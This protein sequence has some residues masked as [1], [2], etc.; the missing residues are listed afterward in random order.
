MLVLIVTLSVINKMNYVT[1][2]NCWG[3]NMILLNFRPPDG[4]VSW[5]ASHKV[6]NIFIITNKNTVADVYIF[7]Y[8]VNISN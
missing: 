4:N 7:N 2:G 1:S 8:E 3:G 6:F 5:S